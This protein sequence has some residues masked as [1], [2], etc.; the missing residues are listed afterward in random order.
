MD[1]IELHDNCIR[2]L[3]GHDGPILSVKWNYDGNYCMSS[4]VDKKC[5]LWNP[6]KGIRIKEYINYT[7]REINDLCIEKDNSKFVSVGG[8]KI[9]YNIDILTGKIIRKFIGHYL[10]INSCCYNYND[11]LLIT[12]SDD[13]SIRIWDVLNRNRNAIQIIDDAYDSIYSI[14][15]IDNYIISSSIDGYIRTY[16]IRMG[17]VTIDYI[18]KDITYIDISYDNKYILISAI[19]IGNYLLERSTGEIIKK[20]MGNKNEKYK[21]QSVF[22]PSGSHIVGGSEDNNICFW[23]IISGNVVKTVTGH[24]G[25]VMTVKYNPQGPNEKNELL[26]TGS[27]DSTI[28]LWSKNIP[29]EEDECN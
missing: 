11:E 15:C 6:N 19:N 5:V 2:T 10:S 1:I 28:K 24:T 9:I 22:V 8:D 7:N 13:K 27:G 21:I 3:K 18:S 23:D 16:D 4:S 12:C 17:R 26:L 25:P 20:Y 29:V 14:L